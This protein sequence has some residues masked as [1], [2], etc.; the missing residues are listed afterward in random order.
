MKNLHVIFTL[1]LL[2][3]CTQPLISTAEEKIGWSIDKPAETIPDENIYGSVFGYN[4][5]NCEVSFSKHGIEFETKNKSGYLA[6]ARLIIF[7]NEEDYDKEII[8]TP[9]TEDSVPHIHMHVKIEGRD[10]PGILMYTQLY[11][12]RLK[13][14]QVSENKLECAIHLSLPDY[15]KSYLAGKFNAIRN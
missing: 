5:S 3:A 7:V 1:S 11:T 13:I 14:K 6:N 9:Q 2:V 12:M 15:K 10:Q 4:M 8:V